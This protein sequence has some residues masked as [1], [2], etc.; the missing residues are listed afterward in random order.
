MKDSGLPLGELTKQKVI[1]QQFNYMTMKQYV[2]KYF[3]GT[4]PETVSHWM[5]Q[6]KVHWFKPGRERFIVLTS[7]S[8]R[9]KPGK[10]GNRKQF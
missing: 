9:V 7:E 8:L 10:Y 6:N 4:R 1:E 2:N 3:P 5:T